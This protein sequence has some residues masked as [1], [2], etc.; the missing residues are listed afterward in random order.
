[1]TFAI[2]LKTQEGPRA[3]LFPDQEEAQEALDLLL[4]SLEFHGW[5]LAGIEVLEVSLVIRKEEP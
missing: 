2:E 5:K 4:M 3:L 1:M